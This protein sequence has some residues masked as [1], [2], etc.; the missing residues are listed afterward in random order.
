MQLLLS[1]NFAI[2]CLSTET[3]GEKLMVFSTR[4][5]PRCCNEDIDKSWGSIS[6]KQRVLNSLLETEEKWAEWNIREC[7][8]IFNVEISSSVTVVCGYGIYCSH[9]LCVSGQSNRV[10][11]TNHS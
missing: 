3:F 1:N 10:A 2:K 11:N 6:F 7:G 4:A 5:V 8:V 9:E